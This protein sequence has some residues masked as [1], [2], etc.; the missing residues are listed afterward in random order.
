MNMQGAAGQFKKD[1]AELVIETLRPI[2]PALRSFSV[3]VI[4]EI[5][6]EGKEGRTLAQE[7]LE[8]FQ[9]KLPFAGLIPA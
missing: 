6:A 7:T 2:K 9:R 3:R 5:L 4:E 1:L 8:R